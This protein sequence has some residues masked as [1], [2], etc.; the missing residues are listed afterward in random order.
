[1]AP[2]RLLLLAAP[3]TLLPAALGQRT[4]SI[5]KKI[6]TNAHACIDDCLMRPYHSDPD[7]GAALQCG[8]PYEDECYCATVTASASVASRHINECASSHCAAGDMTRDISSMRAIYASYCIAA[9]FTQPIVS[10]WYT[11]G[12]GPDDSAPETTAAEATT[13]SEEDKP[14]STSTSKTAFKETSNKDEGGDNGDDDVDPDDFAAPFR[15]SPGGDQTTE[16]TLVTSTNEPEDDEDAA[17]RG[18][19]FLLGAVVVP[20]AAVVLQLL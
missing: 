20:A 7:I 8:D 15:A 4:V 14:T 18:E 10:A 2:F 1:M 3:L 13:T 9:G 16:V 19:L 17:S 5:D 12:D 11:A 6:P